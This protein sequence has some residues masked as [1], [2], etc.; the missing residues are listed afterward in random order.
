MFKRF[1][2]FMV[3]MWVVPMGLCVV[4][5]VVVVDDFVV[6]SGCWCLM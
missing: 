3:L 1:A 6:A 5:Y 4:C 2:V